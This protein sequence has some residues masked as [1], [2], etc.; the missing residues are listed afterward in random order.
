[1][2]WVKRA[3]TGTHGWDRQSWLL[4]C[5]ISLQFPVVLRL[6]RTGGMGEVPSRSAFYKVAFTL[7]HELWS[8]K[9]LWLF[10]SGVLPA[11]AEAGRFLPSMF[12]S[13]GAEKTARQEKNGFYLLHD[14]EC[15][16]F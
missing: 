15:L 8:P 3:G 4:T 12:Y 14:I 16:N 13:P 2:L 6:K 11:K 5:G 10:F 7:L 1:M 9:R